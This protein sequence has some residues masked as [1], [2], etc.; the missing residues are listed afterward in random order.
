MWNPDS[1]KYHYDVENVYECLAQ[2]LVYNGNESRGFTPPYNHIDEGVVWEQYTGL[3]D[4]N[5]TE[6]YEGDIMQYT[7]P[8]EV[9]K[10]FQI[11]WHQFGWGFKYKGWDGPAYM[12][13]F[14]IEHGKIIGNIHE[15]PDLI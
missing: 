4:K 7:F 13:P 1:K 8:D 10:P 3:K 2:Q 12:S 6:I 15:N 11:V 5:G 14:N 9:N